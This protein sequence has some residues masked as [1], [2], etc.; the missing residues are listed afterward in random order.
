M[1]QGS[2]R[3]KARQSETSCTSPYVDPT[4]EPSPSEGVGERS[5]LFHEEKEEA[6]KEQCSRKQKGLE[7]EEDDERRK[8]KRKNVLE[9][10]FF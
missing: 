10:I 7:V 8:Q 9:I 3:G 4:E 1:Y 2:Y 6:M 5:F